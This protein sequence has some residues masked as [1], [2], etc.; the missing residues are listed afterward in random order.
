[1]GPKP[2]VGFGWGAEAVQEDL[3]GTD[4]WLTS[5]YHLWF[6][7]F[8]LWLVAGFALVAIAVEWLGGG[9]GG[10]S[11]VWSGRLMWALVSLAACG[12]CP[13]RRTGCIWPTCRW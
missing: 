12:T 13:T 6:L 8:L 5:I 3:V 7:W 9:G 11:G 2:L 4:A 1:M 10:S